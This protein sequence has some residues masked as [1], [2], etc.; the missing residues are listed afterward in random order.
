MTKTISG[1]KVI[2][3]PWPKVFLSIAVVATIVGALF[4]TKTLSSI[5]KNITTAKEAARP[6]NIKL[7]KITTP[8][9]SDCF[10]LEPA[11]AV[12]N[13]QNVSVGEEK[14]LDF[15]SSEAQSLIKQLGIKRLPTYIVTGEVSKNN[16]ESF[17][18]SNGEIKDNTFVFTKVTPIF[19]D[20]TTKKEMGK[21]TATI[22]TDPACSQCFDPKLTVEAFKKSGVKITDQ[23]ELPWN[24][25][26]GQKIINQYKITKVP[27]FLL[28]SDVD[29]YDNIKSNWPKIGTVE[30]DKTY[31]ARTLLL[32]FRDLEKGQV[33]GLIDVVYLTDSTCSD[34]YK[35]E[36]VQKNILTQGFGVG[37][38]S[39]R[40]VD[41]SGGEGKGLVA[42]YKITKVPT[43]LLSAN[44]DQYVQLKNVW[45]SVGTVETDGWYVFREMKQLGDVT[46]KDLDKNEIIKPAKV[47][48][49]NS[50]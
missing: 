5:D 24:S 36:T 22:L 9:C 2:N 15:N 42:K 28:S 12:F 1:P 32:P 20:A 6:A 40:K 33:L 47:S 10:N 7:T 31:I 45:K 14:S 29:Y 34:C 41:I 21:V 18:K 26:E 48:S 13:K 30:P 19:I 17:V 16:L 37:L 23:K 44:T 25:T 27:T 8:Q 39:E 4:A 43:M 3:L 38:K 50:Q 49:D 11:V 35:P 46:Y